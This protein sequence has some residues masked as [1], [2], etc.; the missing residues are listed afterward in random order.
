MGRYFLIL[1]NSPGCHTLSK[2][3]LTSRKTDVQYSLKRTLLNKEISYVFGK[4][5]AKLCYY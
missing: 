4:T 5:E 3:C 2:A 1:Y